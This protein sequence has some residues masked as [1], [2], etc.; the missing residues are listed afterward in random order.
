MKH[1]IHIAFG[2]GLDNYCVNLQKYVTKY[3]DSLA[4]FFT[5]Q[6]CDCGV[7]EIGLYSYTKPEKNN[8][9]FYSG[10]DEQYTVT[11]K[12]D[13]V[14][15][16]NHDLEVQAWLNELYDGRINIAN[17]GESCLGICLYVKLWNTREV[18]EAISFAKILSS[19]NGNYTVDF[20]CFAAD[21]HT[22]FVGDEG[23][24]SVEEAPKHTQEIYKI[25]SDS[26][27]K[28]HEKCSTESSKVR[29]IIVLQNKQINGVSLNLNKQSI[30]RLL[31][32]YVLLSIQND[33]AFTNN[34]AADHGQIKG[35]GFAILEFDKYFFA[36]NLLAKTYLHIMDKEGVMDEIADV[37]ELAME[38]NDLLR[39][40]YGPKVNLFTDFW[41]KTIVPQLSKGLKPEDI[42]KTV[43]P[44]VKDYVQSLEKKIDKFLQSDRFTLPEKRAGLASLLGEDDELFQGLQYDDEMP[45]IDDCEQEAANLFVNYHN[46]AV[47]EDLP[48]CSGLSSLVNEEGKVHIPLDELKKIKLEMRSATQTIRTLAE[49]MEKAEKA[50]ERDVA[51]T[52]VVLDNGIITIGDEHFKIL[53]APIEEEPF[54]ETF[55]P[56]AG[57]LPEA[58]DMRDIMP[59]IKNQGQIGACTAYTAV[60]AFEYMAKTFGCDLDLS[61]LFVYYMSRSYSNKTNEDCGSSTHAAIQS[62]ID[63]GVCEKNVWTTTDYTEEPSEEAKAMAK[64]HMVLKAMTVEHKLDH[65][66]AAINEGFPVCFGLKI[67]KSFGETQGG[68][69]SRPSA[70]ELNGAEYGYHAMLLCGYS[71]AQKIFIV[72]N[73]WGENFGDCGYCYIPYSYIEDPEMFHGSCIIRKI[74]IEKTAVVV[75][76]K[77]VVNFDTTDSV[78][79]YALARNLLDEAK[80]RLSQMHDTYLAIRTIYDQII[81]TLRNG[82]VKKQL[83][84]C[85]DNYLAKRI[86]KAKENERLKITEKDEALERHDKSTKTGIIS[87]AAVFGILV[88]QYVAAR[89]FFLNSITKY[90]YISWT[91]M[92]ISLIVGVIFFLARNSSRKR[93]ERELKDDVIE[94]TRKVKKLEVEKNELKFRSHVAAYVYDEVFKLREIMIKKHQILKS[95]TANLRLWHEE[96][97]EHMKTLRIESMMPFL[98]VIDNDHLNTYFEENKDKLTDGCKLVN[99]LD[100]DEL[101]EER[102]VKFKYQLKDMVLG[103]IFNICKDFDMRAY[104]STDTE[105]PYL[106]GTK[107]NLIEQISLM[108]RQQKIFLQ[109]KPAINGSASSS[110]VAISKQNETAKWNEIRKTVF[111]T[112][113][114]E[115]KIESNHKLVL[116][117]TVNVNISDLLIVN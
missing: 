37:N 41:D 85:E 62:M 79:R 65:L 68:F 18:E 49:E 114:S 101:S 32:E 15:T 6:L 110:L 100:N 67:F 4:D 70:E 87:I 115:I 108:V 45:I 90:D 75:R 51:A 10:I 71:D 69:I 56:A 1:L 23:E 33:R 64:N 96:Q 44:D 38:V 17:K 60:G 58:C 57:R 14:I 13:K 98:S 29:N 2:K 28:I 31:G 73:S 30:V 36:E 93:L 112:A 95:F 24:F 106:I 111:P 19:C 3:G 83:I 39:K 74:N 21:M 12:Q 117:Q 20:F 26:I 48:G 104:I 116:V 16:E 81:L 80:Y 43:D 84:V 99:L 5:P 53:P 76:R 9:Q 86:S 55:V 52:K 94:A 22:V 11:V 46:H 7:N 78:I 72:R 91:L 35:I 25:S 8:T 42:I 47:S 61:E 102:I 27:K 77:E 63:F 54:A 97:V 113:T 82:S 88:L 40:E 59:R 105:Y 50:I 34:I 89:E 92:S 66:K 109:L 107:E 103:R